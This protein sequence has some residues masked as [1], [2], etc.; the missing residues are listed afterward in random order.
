MVND[1]Y[2]KVLNKHLTNIEKGLEPLFELSMKKEAKDYL[3][4]NI[5]PQK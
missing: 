3:L 1:A 5:K 4:N 2:E